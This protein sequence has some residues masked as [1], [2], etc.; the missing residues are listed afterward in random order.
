MLVNSTETAIQRKIQ[1]LLREGR[2][3]AV[4]K[5]TAKDAQSFTLKT[6]DGSTRT[7]YYSA[8]TQFSKV[9]SAT[10]ADVSNDETVTAMG[11]TTSAGDVT[12]NSVIIGGGF[13]GFGGF[14][15]GMM[16]GNRGGTTNGGGN[17]GNQGGFPQDGGPGGPPPGF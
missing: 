3:A 4:G 11:S 5:V 13:G 7:V 17:S 12:A 16:G 15:G 2:A 14:R 8:S 10:A 6:P 1:D 9:S